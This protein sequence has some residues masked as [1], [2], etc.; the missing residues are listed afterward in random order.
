[1]TDLCVRLVPL[2]NTLSQE[3]QIEIE[4]LVRKKFI[5]KANW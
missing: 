5:K 1:M 4:D 2:F 3:N